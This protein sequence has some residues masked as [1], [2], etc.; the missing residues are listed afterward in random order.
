MDKRARKYFA[1]IL[2]LLVLAQK[3]FAVAA[4]MGTATASPSNWEEIK[5]E[6]K[7]TS[8]TDAMETDTY[9]NGH[10]ERQC[11]RR[12]CPGSHACQYRECI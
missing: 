8:K 10:R 4:S 9:R 7:N 3:P 5:K 2:S 11:Q 12:Y 1:L 6:E